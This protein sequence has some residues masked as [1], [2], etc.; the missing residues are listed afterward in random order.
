MRRSDS[1]TDIWK[2]SVIGENPIMR[3]S[4]TRVLTLSS[5]NHLFIRTIRSNTDAASLTP[6]LPDQ[7]ERG[8]QV[9]GGGGF[10][11]SFGICSQ[12]ILSGSHQHLC[13]K[14]NPQHALPATL[15][16]SPF[17]FFSRERATSSTDRQVQC[18]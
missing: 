17:F 4:V 10:N 2:T 7:F 8:L 14:P 16:T 12:F 1:E 9:R 18:S 11:E 5:S 15:I 3:A 6:S 13:P